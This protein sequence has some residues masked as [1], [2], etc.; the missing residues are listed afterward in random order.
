M[1]TALALTPYGHDGFWLI[2]S[3]AYY[4]LHGSTW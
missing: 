4:W 2:I 3:Q 1:G